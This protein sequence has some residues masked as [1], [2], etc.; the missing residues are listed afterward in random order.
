MDLCEDN[1]KFSKETEKKIWHFLQA[2]PFVDLSEKAYS[3]YAKRFNISEEAFKAFVNLEKKNRLR[4][5][6]KK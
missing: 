5:D 2:I 6:L 4:R 3:N 1:K